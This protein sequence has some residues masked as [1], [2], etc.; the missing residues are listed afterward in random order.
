MSNLDERIS[1]IEEYILFSKQAADEGV[2]NLPTTEK[3]NKQLYN[4]SVNDVD[5]WRFVE[6]ADQHY[7]VSRILFLN[8]VYDYSCFC[9]QQC[10]ENYLKAYLQYKQQTVPKT[11]DLFLLVEQCRDEN[12]S[13]DVFIASHHLSAIVQKYD[14]FYEWARYPVQNVRP[15]VPFGHFYPDDIFVLD[16]FVLKMRE[17]LKNS[18]DNWDIFKDGHFSLR[19]SQ[20]K[21]PEFYDV[22][23]AKNINF[24]N[25]E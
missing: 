9:A 1:E 6:A 19:H 11:H 20:N 15:K 17:I 25:R 10:V 3:I 7:F 23:F 24:M 13:D 14:P 5:Y 16:Y 8:H 22:F 12:G 21:S 2:H 18:N 4:E